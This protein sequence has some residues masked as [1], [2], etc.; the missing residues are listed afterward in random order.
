M[1]IGQVNTPCAGKYA[2][3]ESAEKTHLAKFTGSQLAKSC[4]ARTVSRINDTAMVMRRK[5]VSRGVGPPRRKFRE[6]TGKRR[7]G[8]SNGKRKRWMGNRVKTSQL[9]PSSRISRGAWEPFWR[10]HLAPGHFIA[11]IVHVEQLFLPTTGFADYTTQMF[12]L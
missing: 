1:S 7:H 5:I 6:K 9:P 3:L 8:G 10:E 11:C 2:P 4:V 12:C